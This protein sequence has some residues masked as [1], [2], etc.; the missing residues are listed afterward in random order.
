M[1]PIPRRAPPD[2]VRLYGRG[3][4]LYGRGIPRNHLVSAAAPVRLYGRGIPRSPFIGAASPVRHNRFGCPTPR[5]GCL[6]PTCPTTPV[7]HPPCTGEASQETTLS[8]QPIPSGTTGPAA[9]PPARDASPL[10]NTT[11]PAQP[12]PP[13][14]TGEASPRTPSSTNRLRLAESVRLSNSPPGM[15]RPFLP[16]NQ[17]RPA[18][19]LPF[20]RPILP[21]AAQPNPRRFVAVRYPSLVLVSNLTFDY[22]RSQPVSA[23]LRQKPVSGYA[24]NK[25]TF[26]S[27]G[28]N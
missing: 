3:I 10:P 24:P 13:P 23:Y 15:P 27:K 16:T 1:R 25:S 6:A 17:L 11:L 8:A 5:Q 22:N 2:C 28:L 18:V 21:A 4:P 19:T 9:K 14:C 7:W 20:A 12:P 26:F